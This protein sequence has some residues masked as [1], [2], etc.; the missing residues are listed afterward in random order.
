V[1]ITRT[2]LILMQSILACAVSTSHALTIAFVPR[3]PEARQIADDCKADMSSQP[4]VQMLDPEVVLKQLAENKLGANWST[5]GAWAIEAAPVVQADLLVVIEPEPQAEMLPRP[6]NLT[7]FE[8]KSGLRLEDTVLMR[9]DALRQ[10]VGGLMKNA[11]AKHEAPAA[12]RRIMLV[13]AVNHL[14]PGNADEQWKSLSVRAM[15]RALASVPT[16]TVIDRSRFSAI[17][18]ERKLPSE[19]DARALTAATI[20]IRVDAFPESGEKMRIEASL[21]DAGFKKIE[22]PKLVIEPEN[23]DRALATFA[24]GIAA[25]VAQSTPV[26]HELIQFDSLRFLKQAKS[27]RVSL[28]S[29]NAAEAAIILDPDLLEAQA[30]LGYHQVQFGAGLI[31]NVGTYVWDLARER[32]DKSLGES[33]RRVLDGLEQLIEADARMTRTR[34]AEDSARNLE[35]SLSVPH[36]RRYLTE[37][38]KYRREPATQNGYPYTSAYTVVFSA[39]NQG[40]HRRIVRAYE[41]LVRNREEAAAAAVVDRATFLRATTCLDELL[42]DAQ[43]VFGTNGDELTK[44]SRRVEKWLDLVDKFGAHTFQ[45]KGLNYDRNKDPVAKMTAWC[46]LNA[47]APTMERRGNG[48]YI[49]APQDLRDWPEDVLRSRI[50]KNGLAKLLESYSYKFPAPASS[51]TPAASKFSTHTAL[52]PAILAKKPVPSTQPATSRSPE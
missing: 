11:I 34:G 33:L 20:L 3:G 15:E 43:K 51:K 17:N 40:L 41:R 19:A 29:I 47:K 22:G 48:D 39:E 1:H 35:L 2:C 16:L 32:A 38:Q 46:A 44:L 18:R 13:L 14:D 5:S 12:T 36:L 50:E 9:G 24:S 26:P 49:P 45:S 8:G 25:A 52:P 42:T 37:L 10:T 31:F 6:L 30:V 21:N 7:V 27:E 28:Q 4:G 23:E